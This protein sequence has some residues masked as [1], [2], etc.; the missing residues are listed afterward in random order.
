MVS[1]CLIG[2]VTR[3]KSEKEQKSHQKPYGIMYTV[4]VL[5]NK[6]FP[7]DDDRLTSSET[8]S[9]SQIALCKYILHST[10]L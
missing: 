5:C 8:T 7:S 4:S 6:K 1:L 10:A 3:R 2:G 9:H